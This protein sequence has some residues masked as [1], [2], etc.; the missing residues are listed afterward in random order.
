MLFKD[1][2]SDIHGLL[3]D[4]YVTTKKLEVVTRTANGL[5]FTTHGEVDGRNVKSKAGA[6][7]LN[8]ASGLNL[9]NFQLMS[10]GRVLADASLSVSDRVKL[11][12][13]AEDGRQEKGKASQSNGRL[14]IEFVTP[15]VGLTGEVDVVDGP[16]IGGSVL[17]EHGG[18][19]AGGLAQF[20][21]QLDE[22][23]RKAGLVDM[24]WCVGYRGDGWM[25]TAAT[26]GNLSTLNLAFHQESILRSSSGASTGLPNLP[27][28]VKVG[29]VMAYGLQEPRQRLTAGCSW[30]VDPSSRLRCKADSDGVV[31]FAFRH[32]LSPFVALTL[33]AR[34]DARDLTGGVEGGRTGGTEGRHPDALLP[35]LGLSLSLGG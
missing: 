28:G 1:I 13:C 3:R 16:K 7:D 6:R 10:D 20:N 14:G 18:F 30:Q 32:A 2:E 33:G 17:M 34:V 26:A 12:V 25:A 4:D 11:T 24:G 8:I 15:R 31:S 35:A 22:K 9:D 29:A 5:T 27:P 21:S 19:L 23:D